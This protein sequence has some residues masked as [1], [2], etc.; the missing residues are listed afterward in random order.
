MKNLIRVADD[1]SR[2]LRG[3]ALAPAILLD[4]EG[5]LN[6]ISAFDV[7]WQQAA[8]TQKLAGMAVNCGPQ[9]QLGMIRVATHEPLELLFRFLMSSSSVRKIPPDLRISI[10]RI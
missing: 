4:H 6:L 9:A 3:Q 8:P 2:G 1:S 10:E 7:P 5:E